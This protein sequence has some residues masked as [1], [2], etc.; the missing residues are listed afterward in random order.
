MMAVIFYHDVCLLIG[1]IFCETFSY[2]DF[3]SYVLKK[4]VKL[5]SCLDKRETRFNLS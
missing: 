2:H 4:L 5:F 1:W 3:D